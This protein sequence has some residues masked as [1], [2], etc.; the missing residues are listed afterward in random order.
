MDS[1]YVNIYNEG[2]IPWLNQPGPIFGLEVNRGIYEL[3]RID[4]RIIMN[5]TT[6]ANA[7]EEKERYLA[8]IAAQK[9]AVEDAKKEQEKMSVHDEVVIQK[10]EEPVTP[11]VETTPLTEEDAA[12]DAALEGD[13]AKETAFT[14]SAPSTKKKVKKYTKAQL[15]GMTKAEMKAILAD[16][17]YTSG[18]YAGKYHDTVADLIEKVLKTQ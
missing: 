3:L 7:K 13:N 12:I 17:G 14:A 16:R 5:L 15:E 11:V 1:Y 4:P 18:P 8:K 6:L 2:M 9:Q 10:V